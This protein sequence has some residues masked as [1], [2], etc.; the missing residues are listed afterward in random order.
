MDTEATADA[1]GANTGPKVIR[2]TQF[3]LEDETG[4]TRATL[5][6]SKGRRPGLTLLDEKGKSRVMLTAAT[7][8]PGLLLFDD[9]GKTRARLDVSKD[10][11]V[12]R[13]RDETGMVIWSQP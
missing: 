1:Q 5:A 2:A 4:N 3:I 10:G 8:G 11:P 6:V 9:T 7:A 12:L 13:L